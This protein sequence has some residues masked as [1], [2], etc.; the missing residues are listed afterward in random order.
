[1]G[2]GNQIR[3]LVWWLHYLLCPYVVFYRRCLSCFPSK[4]ILKFVNQL[5]QMMLFRPAQLPADA[6]MP[7][8]C[9]LNNPSIW[10][11]PPRNLPHHAAIC[12]GRRLQQTNAISSTWSHGMSLF[13]SF[14]SWSCNS[15]F[16]PY[17]PLCMAPS[18]LPT[19]YWWM[20]GSNTRILSLTWAPLLWL[21]SHTTSVSSQILPSFFFLPTPAW[22]SSPESSRCVTLHSLCSSLGLPIVSLGHP[23]VS[24]ILCWFVNYYLVDSQLVDI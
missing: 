22:L 13:C 7:M 4:C 18:I 9:Y 8:L 16:Q 10:Q 24:L 12:I 11:D 2:E 5:L 3:Q 14:L 21:F 17:A 1:M 20:F 23:V 15:P 6:D 19:D